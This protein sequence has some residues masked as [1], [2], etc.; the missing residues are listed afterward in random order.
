MTDDTGRKFTRFEKCQVILSSIQ[1]FVLLLALIAAGYIGFSQ[2]NINKKL[3]DLNRETIKINRE[4]TERTESPVI[5]LDTIN[6]STSPQIL[7]FNTGITLTFRNG[8]RTTAK[9]FTIEWH[10]GY[11]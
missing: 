3:L 7:N 11:F 6:C 8:G 4:M 10:L 2:N 5:E 9:D 1:T